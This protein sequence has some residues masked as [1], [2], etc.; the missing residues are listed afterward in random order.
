MS[1]ECW[2]VVAPVGV[3][4]FDDAAI[5]WSAFYHLMFKDNPDVMSRPAIERTVH[6]CAAL[7]GEQFRLFYRVGGKV[8][9]KTLG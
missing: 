1:S 7:V 8:V 3:I 6:K 9:S 5:F 2:S 4:N